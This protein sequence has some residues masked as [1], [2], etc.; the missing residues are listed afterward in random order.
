[1]KSDMA[2]PA[3]SSHMDLRMHLTLTDIQDRFQFGFDP[4][5]H[6]DARHAKTPIEDDNTKILMQRDY[7]KGIT[8]TATE[9]SSAT[10]AE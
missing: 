9:F 4:E 1:M 6:S 10:E 2:P 7:S 3:P 8:S 5:A